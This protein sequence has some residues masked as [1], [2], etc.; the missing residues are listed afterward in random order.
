MCFSPEASFG[1]SIVITTI[2]IIS[3]K[4]AKGTPYWAL[5][6]IPI[7]FGI[8]QLFEGIVWLTAADDGFSGLLRMSTYGFIFFAWVVWPIFIPFALWKTEKHRI[9]KTIY[10]VL[11]FTGTAVAVA[12]VY[13]MIRFGVQAEVEDYSI[14]YKTDTKYVVPTLGAI[15][16][17]TAVVLSSFLSSNKRIWSLGF[18]NLIGFAIS[19]IY[20]LD[21]VISIWCFF[22][23][24]F[25]AAILWVIVG[26]T[27]EKE[28]I[29]AP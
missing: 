15:L 4:K 3:Y 9:R 5:S 14:A 18:L 1:A 24:L 8:Q 29:A 2:G 19:R 21:H 11:I 12:L 17:L 20:F 13:V 10:K 23:A 7:L 22:A 26:A 27:R 6:I 25:S 28:A 16:Y